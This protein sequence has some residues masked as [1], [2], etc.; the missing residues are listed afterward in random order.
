MD[1]FLKSYFQFLRTSVTKNFNGRQVQPGDCYELSDAIKKKTDKSISETTLKRFFGFTNCEHR[2]SVYTLTAL[3]NFSGYDSWEDFTQ[4]VDKAD[5]SSGDL[6]EWS[7]I[8][9]FAAKTSFFNIAS[10][11]RKAKMREDNLLYR[12]WTDNF[13]DSFEKSSYN[14]TIIYGSHRSGKSLALAQWVEARLNKKPHDIILYL[15]KLSLIQSAIYGFNPHKW[16]ANILNLTNEVEIDDFLER[17]Q[18]HP[19]GKIHV[20]IDG[21]NKITGSEKHYYSIIENLFDIIEHYATHQ[22]L[23]FTLVMRSDIYFKTQKKFGRQWSNLELFESKLT[24]N[25]RHA[26]RTTELSDLFI[27]QSLDRYIPELLTSPNAQILKYPSRAQS[28]IRYCL[29]NDV[30]DIN[31][32]ETHYLLI[33]DQF[34]DELDQV[35]LSKDPT[36]SV[37]NFLR[38]AHQG[39]KSFNGKHED[40]KFKII[41]PR[42]INYIYNLLGCGFFTEISDV[43]EGHIYKFESDILEAFVIAHFTYYRNNKLSF[44]QYI[45]ILNSENI[46]SVLYESLVLWFVYFKI[47][48]A[49]YLFMDVEEVQ[50][51]QFINRDQLMIA[52]FSFF[53]HFYSGLKNEQERQVALNSFLE[54]SWHKYLINKALLDQEIWKTASLSVCEKYYSG[55][56]KIEIWFRMT[57]FSLFK[58]NIIDFMDQMEILQNELNHNQTKI[59]T[60]SGLLI[61][62]VGCLSIIFQYIKYGHVNQALVDQSIDKTSTSEE[63]YQ[64]SDYILFDIVVYAV[65]FIAKD[66]SMA[67]I[68]LNK[69]LARNLRGAD[70]QE[71]DIHGLLVKVTRQMSHTE[72]VQADASIL[73][74]INR[75]RDPRSFL[76]IMIACLS[77]QLLTQAGKT[78][79]MQMSE[80][81]KITQSPNLTNYRLLKNYFLGLWPKT[82]TN[83]E[84]HQY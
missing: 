3:S 51:D 16:L 68:F 57:M 61:N 60:P 7:S 84:R 65:L 39:F 82:N 79:D 36:A 48:D 77:L 55:Q 8:R 75:L 71:R 29:T 41:K 30:L 15:D 53:N 23:H 49:D 25:D 78:V 21:F 62:P 31:R 26:L 5:I 44:E 54:S 69:L 22:L 27:K 43:K 46:D 52:S 42:Y 33:Y 59:K 20:I 70:L 66:K 13:F 56:K 45:Q 34:H 73:N 4:S 35:F 67:S 58:W 11:K 80:I 74:Y 40:E 83:T 72:T 6:K 18:D 63:Q 17:H 64:A 12:Y 10:I 19:P 32:K 2:P 24:D 37:Y 47:Q 28:F 81:S 38:S 1:T 50:I 9:T 76:D 14:K